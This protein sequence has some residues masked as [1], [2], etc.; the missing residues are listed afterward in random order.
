MQFF[1]RLNSSSQEPASNIPILV[2]VSSIPEN[3]KMSMFVDPWGM[4]AGGRLSILNGGH[5]GLKL[6]GKVPGHMD[7]GRRFSGA[8]TGEEVGSGVRSLVRN[9]FDG[10]GPRGPARN[11]LTEWAARYAY[12]PLTAFR[13][14]RLLTLF[15]GNG[16]EPLL[17]KVAEVSLDDPGEYEALSYCWGAIQETYG[18]RT[19]D[20]L[21]GLTTSLHLALQS[22]REAGR[23]LVL[24]VD[25][26][27][28]NQNNVQEKKS[29]F[30]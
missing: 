27:C 5:Y 14:I 20:G 7:I 4:V 3:P 6:S 10:W 13:K 17:G 19:A 16:N 26:I 11:G 12:Q 29:R 21:I 1:S 9:L 23:E 15:P 22:I 25:A 24:W 18:L 8:A 30:G 2:R 28:I